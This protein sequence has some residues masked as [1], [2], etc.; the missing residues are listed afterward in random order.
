MTWG[1]ETVSVLSWRVH[2][3]RPRLLQA[4]ACPMAG[5]G[6]SKPETRYMA[7]GQFEKGPQQPAEI[8]KTS[9]VCTVI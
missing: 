6:H 9:N 4:T 7:T 8:S 1:S 5:Q 2:R 3:N